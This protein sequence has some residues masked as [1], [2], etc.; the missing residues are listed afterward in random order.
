MTLIITEKGTQ[1]QHLSSIMDRTSDGEFGLKKGIYEGID[2]LIC[3]LSGHVFEADQSGI[4]LLN[5]I[6]PNKIL[7]RVPDES[8]TQKKRIHQRIKHLKQHFFGDIDSIILATDPDIEGC[9]IAKEVLE[10]YGLDVI[11]D[12]TYMDIHN[13]SESSLRKALNTALTTKKDYIDWERFAF[14]AMLKSDFSLTGLAIT[15]TMN[16]KMK[17]EQVNA[18]YTFGTQQIRA[19]DLVV[20]RYRDHQEFDRSK[21][22]RIKAHTEKGTFVLQD[23]EDTKDLQRLKRVATMLEGQSIDVLEHERKGELEKSPKWY[24]GSHIGS[25][26]S[27]ETKLSIQTIFSNKDSVMQMMYEKGLITYIR[28]EAKGKMPMID[29]DM[30]AEIAEHIAPTYHADR[31]DTSLVKSYLWRKE[32]SKEKVNHTPCTLADRFDISKYNGTERVILDIAAKQILATF[33]PE[34]KVIKYLAIGK[35]TNGFVFA[36]EDK[37]TIDLGW[38]ELYGMKP[39]ILENENIRG[40]A[41]GDRIRIDKVEVEEYTKTPPPLFTEATLLDEIKKKKIGSESTF[42]NI[43]DFILDRQKSS[44]GTKI[45][46]E[47][48]KLNDK[49]QIIPTKKGMNFVDIFPEKLKESLKL[50]EN[51][52]LK[53]YIEDEIDETQALEAKNK[54]SEHLCRNCI[55]CFNE[56]MQTLSSHGLKYAKKEEK[57]KIETDIICPVCKEHRLIEK[58]NVFECENR[59]RVKKGD[60]FV[61]EGCDFSLFKQSTK[62]YRY[63]ITQNILSDLID[64][65]IAQIKA[66]NIKGGFEKEVRLKFNDDFTSIELITL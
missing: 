29:F 58:E 55:Q 30:Y 42:G 41:N 6:P 16:N 62:G 4:D 46:R 9:S 32:D 33:Y 34:A 17:Q 12:I 50:F 28:G 3:P 35:T 66:Y 53:L 23:D 38:K 15:R 44:K 10:Y 39:F 14:C 40:I 7:K 18:F 52:V 25:R 1:A 36:C 56:N 2:F 45:E 48:C 51:G 54:I 5:F 47:Y 11:S 21:H 22:Y 20:S 31:L 64:E 59:K 26:A 13:T 57:I 63:T 43:I 24:D 27:K 8:T 37:E 49:K 60:K 61:T 19:L 65:N